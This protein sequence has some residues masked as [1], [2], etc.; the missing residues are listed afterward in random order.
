MPAGWPT[1]G[2]AGELALLARDAQW[3]LEEEKDSHG[4]AATRRF[5]GHGINLKVVVAADDSRRLAG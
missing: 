2:R 5:E 3:A 4:L 1:R